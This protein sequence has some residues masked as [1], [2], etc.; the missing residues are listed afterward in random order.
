MFEGF[1]NFSFDFSSKFLKHGEF[2]VRF[3]E[4]DVVAVKLVGNG[5]RKGWLL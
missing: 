3:L 1:C 5:N 2:G 4:E